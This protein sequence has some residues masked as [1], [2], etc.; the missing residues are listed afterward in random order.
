MK[1]IALIKTGGTIPQIKQ[2]HGDFEELVAGSRLFPREQS[3]KDLVVDA[4]NRILV[5][6]PRKDVIRIFEEKDDGY[7]RSD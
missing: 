4:D 2:A 1:P 3:L 6:D 7:E 5:L